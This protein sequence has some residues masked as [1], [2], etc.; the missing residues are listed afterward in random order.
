ML[1]PQ[2]SARMMK[3]DR[4]RKRATIDLTKSIVFG[5]SH[6]GKGYFKISCPS[7]SLRLHLPPFLDT[8]KLYCQSIYYFPRFSSLS[9]LGHHRPITA[10]D[11]SLVGEIR[12]DENTRHQIDLVAGDCTS[13]TCSLLHHTPRQYLPSSS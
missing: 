9:P 1:L 2:S 12:A 3:A 8:N 5:C 6:K 13:A 4:V 7:W 11:S 10:A